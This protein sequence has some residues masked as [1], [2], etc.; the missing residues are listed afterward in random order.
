MNM[1]VVQDVADPPDSPDDR[2]TVVL[3]VSHAPH[4]TIEH[5]PGRSPHMQAVAF[6]GCFGWLHQATES[7]LSDTAILLCPGLGR[8]ASR[9][10]RSYRIM[11]N[12]FATEGY[13]TLRF[14]YPGAGDSCEI[15]GR[16]CWTVWQ[17]SVQTAADWL[18]ANTGARRIVMIGL[19]IGAT[20]AA[21]AA[22]IRDDVVGLVLLEPV[23]RGKSY[24]SQLM[25]ESRL[26]SDSVTMP[27]DGLEIDGL[28]LDI[29]TVKSLRQVDLRQVKLSPGCSIS[30]FSQFRTPVLAACV[31]A[32]RD[33]GVPIVLQN[34]GSL[35]A[36]LRPCHL[37]DGPDADFGPILSWLHTAIPPRQ[38][39]RTAAMALPR[40]LMSRIA[41]LQPE[42]SVESPLHFGE[43]GHL[44]G[45]LCRP[46]E[47]IPCDSAVIIGN[48]GG[49]PHYGLAR[50]AV[51]FA[52]RL[53]ARG[54]ASL[55][56]D[57][58]GL[59]DS[60]SSPDGGED[61]TQIFGIDRTPAFGA[62]ID[63][64]K[65]LGFQ[66]F[67]LNGLCSGAYHAFL[68]ALADDRVTALLSINL[69]WFTVRYDKPGPESFARQ[70]IAELSHRQVR[71]L[72]LFSAGDPGIK[73]LEQHFGAEGTNLRDTPSVVASI[74]A[75]LDHDLTRRTMR[76]IAADKMI[77][78]LQQNP[79]FQS[80]S[81]AVDQNTGPDPIHASV[82]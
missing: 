50:F 8:D 67:A 26:R 3:S 23:L 48:T 20:L 80:K 54:I 11:A 31:D 17:Q 14:D 53:A 6:E 34:L 76:Q 57:F 64:M 49:D 55:R 37:T 70:A 82:S 78:F 9:A 18:R 19:R 32:W 45:V 29:G 21:L 38:I 28:C 41:T 52:R 75:G 13:P 51:E 77:D 25:V 22:S 63:M 56:I 7:F 16:E 47:D 15:D 81:P 68:G 1:P 12:Q 2:A 10:H 66:H 44:V 43:N 46:T 58:A 40:S 35:E 65:R 79:V 69:P 24:V 74:V 33:T 73:A 60:I 36:L 5:R 71:A 39:P 59:G 42:N 61:L 4:G 30:I 72:L 27:D 62:A